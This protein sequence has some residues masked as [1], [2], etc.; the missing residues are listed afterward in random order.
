MLA[1]HAN[2]LASLRFALSKYMGKFS[3]LENKDVVKNYLTFANRKIELMKT[4]EYEKN[5]VYIVML[6]GFMD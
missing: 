1:Y 6:G 2:V 3:C 5:H 4:Y